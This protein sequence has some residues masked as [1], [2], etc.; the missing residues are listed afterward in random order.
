MEGLDEVVYEGQYYVHDTLFHKVLGDKIRSSFV[1]KEHSKTYLKFN[2]KTKKIIP[3]TRT[4]WF[5][6]GLG[7]SRVEVTGIN[8]KYKERLEKIISLQEYKDTILNQ[9]H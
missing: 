9:V 4:L 5:T 2:G 3:Y 6:Q 1:M 7:I 8:Y